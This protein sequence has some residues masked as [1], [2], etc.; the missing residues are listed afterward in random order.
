MTTMNHRRIVRTVA[1]FVLASALFA[2]SLSAQPTAQSRRVMEFESVARAMIAPLDL[3]T[4]EK[5]DRERAE[6]GAPP[7]F[8]IPHQA[9]MTPANDGTWESLDNNEMLWRLRVASPSAVSM[10][11]GFTRYHMPVG[12][13]LYIYSANGQY[14]LRPFTAADNM[15]HGQLWTP[16]IAGD[17]V[18]IELTIPSDQIGDLVL[19]LGSINV[20]YRR[21]GDILNPTESVA[22]S[23]VCNVDVVCPSASTWQLQAPA[24]AVISTGGFLFCT[25]FMVNNT[26]YDYT[27]YFMTAN[28]CGIAS[29]NAASLVVFWNYQNS[30]CRGE[31]GGAGSGDGTLTEFNTGSSFRAGFSGSDMTLVQ[32]SNSPNPQWNV[33]WA[34][35][36]RTG[37]NPP[38]GACIHHPNTDEKRISFY[39][40]SFH[41]PHGSSWGCSPFPGPGDNT[42]ISVYWSLGITEPGSS[43]SP[44][45]DNNKRVIGQLHGGTSDCNATGDLLSDC[46]GRF[47]RSWTGNAT[48]ST[49]LSNWL[50][51]I[52]LGAT[53]LETISGGGLP[54]SPTGVVHCIGEP[55]GPFTNSST[56]YTIS[57]QLTGSA[58]YSVSIVGGGSLP[59][60]INGGS[61]PLIG[62]LSTGGAFLVTVS[63]AS[64]ANSLTEGQ[65]AS[66]VQFTDT[67]NNITTNRVFLLEVAAFG[68][69]CVNGVCTIDAQS[70]CTGTWMG[71]GTDCNACRPVND[72]CAS[73]IAAVEGNNSGTN[74]GATT[75]GSATCGT[76]NMDV[77]WSFTPSTTGAVQFESCGS[78][79]VAILSVFGG[80][81]GSELACVDESSGSCA[82]QIEATAQTTY[83][84]RI[85][86][87]GSATGSVSLNII[88]PCADGDD[89]FDGVCN[90]EDTCPGQDD[91]ADGDADGIPDCLD[92]CPTIANVDQADLD[93]DGIGDACDSDVDGDGLAEGDCD[94]RD[95]SVTTGLCGP[96]SGALTLAAMALLHS[97]VRRRKRRC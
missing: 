76:G 87:S 40:S 66:T 33:S 95:A 94:D 62:T 48:N 16:P 5:E 31:P 79:V 17:E 52:N 58:N 3:S 71:A 34:G 10:N 88:V 27:P 74:V 18:V 1:A 37:A 89:D 44:L 46:Y 35:W 90:D 20:G 77:W 92:N 30:T 38:S 85:A 36:D 93:S 97:S 13:R 59:V 81:G 51:P 60:T 69:C 47:S 32:L 57:N 42:H 19:E 26:A 56:S 96:C 12:G 55:G 15:E 53:T 39:D 11:L 75:D 45:F 9:L 49:R 64:G 41:A 61:G 22:K 21:F 43:G 68:A 82:A 24:V 67:T 14:V 54:V 83:L 63:L 2:R 4:I 70:Q 25:G 28:H 23:L 91:A 8:A 29:G 78:S 80:C 50:D 84:I 6:S 73:A 86:G 72:D 65:Y 7:R